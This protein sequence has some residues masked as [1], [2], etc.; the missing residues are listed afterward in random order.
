MSRLA[1]ASFLLLPADWLRRAVKPGRML[2]NWWLSGNC[3]PAKGCRVAMK[4]AASRGISTE[5]NR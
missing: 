4:L 1:S 3:T 5:V 2:R